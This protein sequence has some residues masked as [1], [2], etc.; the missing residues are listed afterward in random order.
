[1][2]T[3]LGANFLG[4]G[5]IITIDKNSQIYANFWLPDDLSIRREQSIGI[6]DV[7]ND[8]GFAMHYRAVQTWSA[9]WKFSNGLTSF[10]MLNVLEAKIFQ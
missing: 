4:K 7:V 3:F 1:M 9:I 10:L 2:K 6:H 5:T 8:Q